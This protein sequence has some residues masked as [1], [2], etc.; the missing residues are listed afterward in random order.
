MNE[1][2]PSTLNRLFIAGH[3]YDIIIWVCPN[4]AFN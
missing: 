2:N 4:G 3:H 1:D